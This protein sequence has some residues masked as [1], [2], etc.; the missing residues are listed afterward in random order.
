MQAV[1]ADASGPSSLFPAEYSLTEWFLSKLLYSIYP[2]VGGHFQGGKSESSPA[3][4]WN[5][6]VWSNTQVRSEDG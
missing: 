5:P 6:T 1:I 2:L 3:S 4:D